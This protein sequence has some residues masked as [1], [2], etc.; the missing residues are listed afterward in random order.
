VGN[1]VRL[2]G[3]VDDIHDLLSRTNIPTI[4]AVNGN[5]IVNSDYPYYY[6]RFGTHA[7][8]CANKLK[9]WGL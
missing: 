5:D 2:S 7:Q 9:S 6:G 3:A 4:T 1:G 8:I